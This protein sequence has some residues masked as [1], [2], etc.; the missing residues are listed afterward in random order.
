MSLEM[1]KWK[2]DGIINSKVGI[3][4]IMTWEGRNSFIGQ[5]GEN[6]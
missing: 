3:T 4:S 6:I 2:E 5:T 1:F